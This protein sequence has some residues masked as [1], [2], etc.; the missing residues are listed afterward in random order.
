MSAHPLNLDINIPGLE[1]N[2]IGGEWRP[3]GNQINVIS[4]TTEEVIAK[5]ADP[6]IEDAD[7]A[8]A[9]AR[10]AFDR[11]AW[12]RLSVQQRVATC[13]RLV[14]LMESR[15]AELNRAWTFESGPTLAH[16]EMINSGAGVTIWRQALDLAPTLKWEEQ[17]DGALV[18]REP[19]GTVLGV[20][21][22]NGPIVLMGMKIIPALLAG[23]T[24]VIKH[25]PESALTSRIIAQC[26]ADAEFPTGTVSVLAAGTEV[27]QHLVGHP[28]IDMVA[29]TGGT[30]IGV[31]VVKRTAD[32]LARTAL[33]LGG[34][35]PAI[36]AQDANLEDVMQTLGAGTTGF[37]GQVCVNL[38]RVIVPAS[39]YNEVA[40]VLTRYFEAIRIG[41]PFDAHND[42]GPLA[43]AR[44]RDRVEGYVARAKQD[45]ASIATGGKRPAHMNRGWFYEPTLLTDVTNDMAVAQEEIF[46][47]VTALIA[48]DSMDE[49]I[50]IANDSPFG[51]AC[52]IYTGDHDR[53]L[54]IARQ[55]RAG[56]VAINC[57]GVSLTQPFGG[58]KQS[59][60][61]RE[62][63]AEGIL[64]FTQIKQVI[65]GASYQNAQ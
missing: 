58:Y 47:P 34:K 20:L 33:E 4:P 36:I 43:V 2:F 62:C 11:G 39:R 53:A 29:L 19:I 41:D 54:N 61:G 45:G 10:E 23:C 49:A 8:V 14:E 50:H 12:P 26:I 3:S 42:Q 30:A 55:I 44:A 15:L 5:V 51:L 22:F 31:D 27:S 48:Y 17:R 65:S 46:G 13:T 60:W 59:G 64:E 16:G 63:G 56:G 7:A 57:A 37:M 40:D 21:T 38:S 24:V 32:R 18:W 6:T 52:S 9:F 35:S 28:G 1:A 25:A